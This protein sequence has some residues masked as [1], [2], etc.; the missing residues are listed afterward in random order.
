[1]GYDMESLDKKFVTFTM[2]TALQTQLRSTDSITIK[3][4]VIQTFIMWVTTCP[5]TQHHITEDANI[6]RHH[7]D[8]HKSHLVQCPP[9]KAK[10][11][12]FNQGISS[13]W[14]WNWCYKDKVPPCP[15]DEGR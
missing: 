1:M 3:I 9:S 14:K 12:S 10:C 4:K 13:G 8:S 6:L 11:Y 15:I 5:M 7:R 2:I